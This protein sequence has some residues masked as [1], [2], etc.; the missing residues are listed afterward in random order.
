VRN[1]GPRVLPIP[2]SP[3]GTNGDRLRPP[4]PAGT[5]TVAQRQQLFVRPGIASFAVTVSIALGLSYV[6][7]L[8][9]DGTVGVLGALTTLLWTIPLSSSLIGLAGCLRTRRVLAARRDAPPVGPVDDM[10]IVVVPT[11]GRLDTYPALERVVTSYCEHLPALFPRLRID[12]VIEEKCAARDAIEA[13]AGPLVRIVTVPAA[14]S[15]PARTRFKA[16]ANHFANEKRIAEGEAGV[17]V[18]V[19]H[20]DDDTGVGADTAVE[21]ARFVGAQ[22]GNPDGLHLAQG[23]LTFPREHAASRLIW[24]ADSI[25]PAQD[26]SLYAITTG[27]G[28]PRAGLHGELLIV[29]ASIEAE[30]GWDFGPRAV[31]EDSQFALNFVHR[32]PG[33]SGWFPGRSLGATPVNVTDLLRQRERWAWGLLELSVDGRIPLRDRLL[34]I[35][36]MIIWSAG[37][38][39]HVGVIVVAGILLGDFD[40]FPA[41]AALL[42]LWAIN[43][44]FQV[45]TYWE[46]LRLNVRASAEPRNTWLDRLCL[47]PLVPFFSLMESVGFLRGFVRFVRHY[48]PAFA[49]I[50]KPL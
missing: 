27:R 41:V 39:Q 5:V 7:W 21:L 15:T 20:M 8:L 17:D 44:G 24:L 43:V 45:W 23:V 42:P 35:H 26:V 33:R 1:G 6:A 34:L 19:L 50:A 25:R 49:V 47:L 12:V 38:F 11:I 31:V 29:R 40:T 16:R 32:H 10:L 37:P 4:R 28:T 13:L 2:A 30:I 14:Y 36:N 9:H 18:W 22:Q 48:E 46:G 3:N